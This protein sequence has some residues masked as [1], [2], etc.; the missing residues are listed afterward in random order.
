M[1][2][3]GHVFSLLYCNPAEAKALFGGLRPLD[4]AAVVCVAFKLMFLF[5]SAIIH[6]DSIGSTFLSDGCR[7]A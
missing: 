6:G 4:R 2:V 5:F 7:T 3:E 1:E